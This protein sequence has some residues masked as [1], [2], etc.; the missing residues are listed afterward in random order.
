MP[1]AAAMTS[2]TYML[3]DIY[4]LSSDRFTCKQPNPMVPAHLL[5]LVW[6][7]VQVDWTLVAC[8]MT[9]VLLAAGSAALGYVTAEIQL[10]YFLEAAC[11]V[12]EWVVATITGNRGTALVLTAVYGILILIATPAPVCAAASWPSAHNGGCNLTE[13][14]AATGFLASVSVGMAVATAMWRDIAIMMYYSTE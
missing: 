6:R 8:F 13:A 10:L 3:R 9:G 5:L 7:C 4:F 12:A 11:L 2:M 14:I 1:M